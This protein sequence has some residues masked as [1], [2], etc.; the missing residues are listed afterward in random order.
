M[1]EEYTAP[2]GET[3]SLYK[4]GPYFYVACDKGEENRWSK[5]Y[6][7]EDDAKIEFER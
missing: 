6:R 3:I 1:F 5:I 7:N 4:D 2:S